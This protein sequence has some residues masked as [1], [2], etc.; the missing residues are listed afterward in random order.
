MSRRNG[1][2][3]AAIAAARMHADRGMRRAAFRISSATPMKVSTS[4]MKISSGSQTKR[5]NAKP[6]PSTNSPRRTEIFEISVSSAPRESRA[7]DHRK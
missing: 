2:T 1:A 6:V 7:S 4:Q 5:L 3:K